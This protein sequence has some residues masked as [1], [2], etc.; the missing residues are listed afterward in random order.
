MVISH[1]V[2]DIEATLINKRGEQGKVSQRKFR[3][4]CY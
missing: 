2:Y 4:L 1:Y 3:K